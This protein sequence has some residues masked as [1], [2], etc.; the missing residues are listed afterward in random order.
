MKRRVAVFDFD[1]TLISKDSLLEFI[2]FA[3][4][5]ASFLWGFLLYSPMLVLMNMRLYPNWKA[6]E[7]VFS[8]FFRG[9]SIENFTAYGIAFANKLETFKNE[10]TLSLLKDH[11]KNEDTVYIISASIEDWVRPWCEQ[12]GNVIVL[13]TKVDVDNHGILTGRFLTNNCYGQE[14]VFR[15]L[16]VEP[17]RN[18]YE[19][20][21]Y[22]DSRGDKEMIEFA[23]YGKY[24]N[25]K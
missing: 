15:L 4:G 14:K 16:Q 22:G 18:E 23:D 1:G 8:H 12:M 13:G 2:K 7:K 19:L 6:K 17:N 20:Y 21:A 10:E 9:L 25:K 5:E 11:L 24:V 3:C